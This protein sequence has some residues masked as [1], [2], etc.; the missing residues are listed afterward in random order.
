MEV[1]LVLSLLPLAHCNHSSEGVGS[2]LST[3]TQLKIN[4]T[5]VVYLQSTSPGSFEIVYLVKS[6]QQVY[7]S[8]QAKLRKAGIEYLLQFTKVK[9]WASIQ[10]LM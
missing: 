10:L 6:S 5:M 8:M 1:W 4:T 7:I 9:V 3:S 2:R